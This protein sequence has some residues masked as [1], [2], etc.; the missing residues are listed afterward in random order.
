MRHEIEERRS[1]ELRREEEGNA[2][3]GGLRIDLESGFVHIVAEGSAAETAAAER[4]AVEDA[5]P[6]ADDAAAAAAAAED[7]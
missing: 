7:K 5:A 2:T 1:K 6:E 3:K 4:A